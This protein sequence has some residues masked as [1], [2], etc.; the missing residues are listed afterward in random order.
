MEPIVPQI[1]INCKGNRSTETGGPFSFGP[2]KCFVQHLA[3]EIGLKPAQPAHGPVFLA[4][5]V[6]GT[7]LRAGAHE[8]GP[9]NH[10]PCTMHH[11]TRD[12]MRKPR[13]A[14]REPR[15]ANRETRNTLHHARTANHA[16]CNVIPATH[17]KGERTANR[18]TGLEKTGDG[19]LCKK[20]IVRKTFGYP[21]KKS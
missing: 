16:P 18:E 9:A 13:T 17:F 20:R 3:C 21:N 2:E 6:V 4:P 14:N 12:T 15:T 7:H 1:Q 8:P 19:R 11:E 5:G 10:A